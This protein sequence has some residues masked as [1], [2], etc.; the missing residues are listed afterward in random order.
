MN[1]YEHCPSIESEK[2]QLRFVTEQDRDDLLRVYSDEAA[3]PLFN[4]DNCHGDDFHYTTA[5]RMMEAIRFW[6]WSYAQGYFVRWSIVDRKAGCAVGTVELFHRVSEDSFNGSAVLRLDLRSDY[7]READLVDILGLI[8][9]KAYGWFGSDRIVTKA[10]PIATERIKALRKTGFAPED[11]PLIGQDGTQY[12]D[13]WVRTEISQDTLCKIQTAY[14]MLERKGEEL[15]HAAEQKSLETETGWYNGHYQKSTE[16]EWIR[17]SFP[18]PVIGVKGICDM[19]IQ[20]DGITVSAK[21]KRDAA[22]AY[23]FEKLEYEFEA[24][25][26]EDYLGDYYQPGEIFDRMKE[27]I[28]AGTETEIGFSFPFSFDT[29]G[30]KVI[31]FAAFLKNEGFYNGL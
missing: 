24:Y 21:L 11:A 15:V 12:G 20:F 18:I 29:D 10:K 26:V 28:L 9:P 4:S 5:E 13:Y 25:G 16:G 19:E 17:Q 2:F 23:P 7:E 1:V 27:R 6:I 22:L 3:V 8:V 30:E 14:R 31:E